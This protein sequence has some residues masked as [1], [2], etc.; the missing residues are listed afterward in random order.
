MKTMKKLL[1]VAAV[2]AVTTMAGCSSIAD[3]NARGQSLY[4]KDPAAY[5]KMTGQANYMS[6]T[7]ENNVHGS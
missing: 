4:A 2:A 6:V 3:L 5:E 7:P 1:I